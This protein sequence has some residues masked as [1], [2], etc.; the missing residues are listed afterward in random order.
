MTSSRRRLVIGAILFVAAAIVTVIVVLRDTSNL[1]VTGSASSPTTR[2]DRSGPTS[3]TITNLAASGTG[4]QLSWDRLDNAMT[5]HVTATGPQ[6]RWMWGGYASKVLFGT[7]ETDTDPVVRPDLPEVRVL[8]P[9]PG[10]TYRW[11]VIA[12]SDTGDVVATS[13]IQ[14][15]TYAPP[16]GEPLPPRAPRST[17]PALSCSKLIPDALATKLF[18]GFTMQES[19]P[20]GTALNGG[21][22]LTCGFVKRD[23]EGTSRVS[24][25]FSCSQSE[26]AS[27]PKPE[28]GVPLGGV[29]RAAQIAV[30]DETTTILFQSSSTKCVVDQRSDVPRDASIAIAKE[31]DAQLVP[32]SMWMPDDWR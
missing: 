24:V 11:A 19:T 10:E 28:H 20:C 30:E 2:G 6:G 1:S 14:S 22:P 21:C 25:T 13:E 29:G 16:A 15:F 8:V 3:D 32:G 5:Y 7:L 27:F 18:P 23:D 26:W 31:I 4:P 12:F 17:P 9:K